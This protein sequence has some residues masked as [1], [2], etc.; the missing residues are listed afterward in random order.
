MA[1]LLTA[2]FGCCV[3]GS[4]CTLLQQFSWDRFHC[5]AMHVGAETLHGGCVG[6]SICGCG[7]VGSKRFVGASGGACAG[8]SHQH[9]HQHHPPPIISSVGS[10]EG[11]SVNPVQG[12]CVG[13]PLQKIP[14]SK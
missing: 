1:K 7:L 8:W 6:M 2:V 13:Y 4:I 12:G 10:D 11:V 9:Q 14:R 5:K 3:G